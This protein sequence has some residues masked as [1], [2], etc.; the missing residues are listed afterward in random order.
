MSTTDEWLKHD[1]ANYVIQQY[2]KGPPAGTEALLTNYFIAVVICTWYFLVWRVCC[3][4][5][6]G[7]VSIQLAYVDLLAMTCKKEDSFHRCHS[8]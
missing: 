3:A 8:P 2:M 7:H 4:L 5:V 1:F 6:L